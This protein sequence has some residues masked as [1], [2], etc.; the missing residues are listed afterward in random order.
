MTARRTTIRQL[1]LTEGVDRNTSGATPVSITTPEGGT[2]YHTAPLADP[3]IG[4]LR[5]DRPQ[6]ITGTFPLF[7]VVRLADGAP[8]A[9]ANLWLIDMIESKPSPNMLKFASI[10]D[11][12]V[13]FRRYLDNE[14]V[15][16]LAFPASKRQHPTYRYSASIRLAVRA[17]ELS[18]GAVVR[19]YRWLMTEAGFRPANAP[20]VESGRFIEFRE[21]KG[22]S[23]AI[24]VKTTEAQLDESLARELAVLHQVFRLRKEL[25]ALR[26]GSVLPLQPR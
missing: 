1:P 20:W 25:A 10:A 23:R 18:P 9:E 15:D 4:K 17:G 16:W 26:G 14:G 6:W 2:I 8:W 19:F 13:A 11:D 5:D 22:F 21:H 24:E 3:A 12:L 7:P